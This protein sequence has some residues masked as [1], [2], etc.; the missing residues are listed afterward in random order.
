[1][2][3]WRSTRRLSPSF[4][5]CICFAS[6]SSLRGRRRNDRVWRG[7]CC[8]KASPSN[9]LQWRS[10]TRSTVRKA[11]RAVSRGLLPRAAK[12]WRRGNGAAGVPHLPG[13]QSRQR[14]G[15]AGLRLQTCLSRRLLS[16]RDR[17]RVKASASRRPAGR[18]AYRRSGTS[19]CGAG[20]GT[21][22]AARR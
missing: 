18:S 6:A 19:R 16:S 8:W 22:R 12:H 10:G 3:S 15:A 7:L 13:A 20:R 11:T 17:I 9:P 21:R 2:P 1:M 5:G 14:D 4:S